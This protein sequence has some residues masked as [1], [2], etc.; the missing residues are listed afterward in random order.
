VTTLLRMLRASASGLRPLGRTL[1]S[2]ASLALLLLVLAMAGGGAREV[3]NWS[4]ILPAAVCCA[5][6]AAAPV[7]HG[8]VVAGDL[9]I[10]AVARIARSRPPFW[11]RQRS[12][13]ARGLPPPRAPD[14]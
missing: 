8:P 1:P 6:V 13:L 10:T 4:P 12:I 2:G 3:S 11:A 14:A 9:E 5:A 7:R